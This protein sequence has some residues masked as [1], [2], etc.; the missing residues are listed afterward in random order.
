METY[1]LLT[2]GF[3]NNRIISSSILYATTMLGLSKLVLLV[4][5]MVYHAADHDRIA[6]WSIGVLVTFLI[7]DTIVYLAVGNIYYC[8][9]DTSLR[10]AALNN[11]T[12]DKDILRAQKIIAVHDF[13]DFM[14]ILIIF[15]SEIIINLRNFF[16]LRK[17][18]R[19][20][21]KFLNRTNSVGA[22]EMG[23]MDGSSSR[24]VIP[25]LNYLVCDQHIYYYRTVNRTGIYTNEIAHLFSL[26]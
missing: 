20:C 7:Q 1:P 24:N 9:T 26:L 11:M 3:L 21:T 23:N 18:K 10:T 13:E 17:Y 12:V 19:M 8:H 4:K 16:K 5:P 2:C 6:K 14:F 25:F 15:S 22:I